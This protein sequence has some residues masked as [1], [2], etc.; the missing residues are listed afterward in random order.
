M[1]EEAYA[2][3]ASTPCTLVTTTEHRPP[4]VKCMQWTGDATRLYQQILYFH[5]VSEA[6]VL[7]NLGKAN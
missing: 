3:G 6:L 5:A 1:L 7:A 4:L 2:A